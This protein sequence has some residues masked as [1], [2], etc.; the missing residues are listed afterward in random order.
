M[1]GRP[2]SEYNFANCGDISF[3]NLIHHLADRSQRMVCWY[4]LLWRNVAEHSFLLVIVA[5][6]SLVSLVFLHSDEFLELKLQLKCVFQQTVRPGAPPMTSTVYSCLR[7]R[8][9]GPK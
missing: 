7:S 1:D 8:P 3:E 4:T 9:S 5:A 2:T 6:H